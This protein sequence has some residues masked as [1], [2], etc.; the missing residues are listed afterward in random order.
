[1]IDMPTLLCISSIV[2]VGFII[3]VLYLA[4]RYWPDSKAM[5]R[6]P[7]QKQRQSFIKRIKWS[8][9]AQH[10]YITKRGQE[11]GRDKLTYWLFEAVVSMERQPSEQKQMYPTVSALLVKSAHCQL[12]D[13]SL[14]SRGISSE[15]HLPA[16]SHAAFNRVYM[17][18]FG[19]R[20]WLE[21]D[22]PYVVRKLFIEPVVEIL[23]ELDMFGMESGNHYFLYYKPKRLVEDISTF[24]EE[25]IVLFEM[26]CAVNPALTKFE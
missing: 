26:M 8:W 3:L 15:G 11:Y 19:Y 7:Q 22:E 16:F 20:F 24:V 13:F 4:E 14:R 9:L 1:M 23:A 17:Q 10:G 5:L 18:Q 25:G 21:A 12:P 6:S 2:A